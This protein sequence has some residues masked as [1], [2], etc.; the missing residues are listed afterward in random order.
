[1]RA[2]GR[3]SLL[4]AGKGAVSQS[5]RSSSA[6]PHGNATEGGAE[7]GR[8]G[9]RPETSIPS[10]LTRQGLNSGSDRGGLSCLRGWPLAHSGRPRRLAEARW[11]NGQCPDLGTRHPGASQRLSRSPVVGFR[12]ARQ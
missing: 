4:R 9:G 7:E 12:R 11:G 10:V 2:A 5:S 3:W 6:R 1:M 8:A